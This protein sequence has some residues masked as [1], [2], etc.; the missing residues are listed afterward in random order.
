MKFRAEELLRDLRLAWC[1]GAAGSGAR[2][3]PRADCRSRLSDCVRAMN[4][5]RHK[6]P[7]LEE[8]HFSSPG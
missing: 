1:R 3:P 7:Y 2:R 5:G 8:R 4:Y 6:R